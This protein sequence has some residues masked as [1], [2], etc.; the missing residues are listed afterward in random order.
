[1]RTQPYA[2]RFGVCFVRCVTGAIL[3]LTEF[4]SLLAADYLG[5]VWSERNGAPNLAPPAAV[6]W[7]LP[8]AA[9]KV[10]SWRWCL[11]QAFGISR[12]LKRLDDAEVGIGSRARRYSDAVGLGLLPNAERPSAADFYPMK[13]SAGFCGRFKRRTSD[14][15]RPRLFAWSVEETP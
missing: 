2:I 11:P 15:I 8:D 12:N 9:C 10:I 5:A 6:L 4:V 13:S 1:M 7:G 3:Q 14:G